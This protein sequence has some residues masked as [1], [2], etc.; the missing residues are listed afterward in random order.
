MIQNIFYRDC[1][2]FNWF[3][4][5]TIFYLHSVF[6]DVLNCIVFWLY[7]VFCNLGCIENEDLPSIVFLNLNKGCDGDDFSCSCEWLSPDIV[8]YSQTESRHFYTH[9]H[10]H[11]PSR[12]RIPSFYKEMVSDWLHKG[13]SLRHFQDLFTNLTNKATTKLFWDRSD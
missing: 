10:R 1:S 9:A 7:S 11:V 5:L 3:L 13:W 12:P 2:W 4:I 8:R 6:F